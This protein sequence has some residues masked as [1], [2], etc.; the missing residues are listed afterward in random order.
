MARE[1]AVPM[2]LVM[3]VID[4]ATIDTLYPGSSGKG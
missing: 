2:E 1:V 4:G 3:Y